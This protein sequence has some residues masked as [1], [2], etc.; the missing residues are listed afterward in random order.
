MID[1]EET[2]LLHNVEICRNLLHYLINMASGFL[3]K[4]QT[5]ERFMCDDKDSPNTNELV[6]RVPGFI[7]SCV[8]KLAPITN[9]SLIITM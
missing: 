5:K 6:V 8:A 2:S 4:F 9:M 7:E 1:P 3:E